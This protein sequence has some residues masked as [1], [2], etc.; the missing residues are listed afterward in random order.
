[1]AFSGGVFTRLFS[2]V[3]DREAGIKINSVRMEQEFDG[4]AT[5]LSTCL[6]KNG[7]QT[8][9]AK[10]PFAKGINVASAAP[11]PAEDGDM[12][13][14][15]DGLFFHIDGE[16]KKLAIGEDGIAFASGE[17]EGE[18]VTPSDLPIQVTASGSVSSQSL[19]RIPLPGEDYEWA[20]VLI[21]NIA[22]STAITLQGRFGTTEG[23]DVTSNIYHYSVQGTATTPSTRWES[24]GSQNKWILAASMGPTS[25]GTAH[26]RIPKPS[27]TGFRKTLFWT[28]AYIDNNG[29][30]SEMKGV[31]GANETT[32][33]WTHFTLMASTGTLSFNYRV[34][35][36]K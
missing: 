14:T 24:S 33:D 3:S 5:G 26:V 28:C 16:T 4:I 22:P 35:G 19:G 15:S 6:L 36:I 13:I 32:N 2:W 18:V 12:W 27:A 25:G 17:D 9:T 29:S 30:W 31:I 20:D 8:A 11:N 34:I 21:Y 10:I 23:E 1:M 7:E